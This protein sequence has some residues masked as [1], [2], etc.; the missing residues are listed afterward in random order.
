MTV[1]IPKFVDGQLLRADEL[2]ALYRA[3]VEVA[4]A[5]GLRLSAAVDWASGDPVLPRELN[6]L[7]GD[8]VRAYEHL[9]RTPPEWSFGRFASGMAITASQLNEIGNA[10]R[11]LLDG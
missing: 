10:V 1:H 6:R 7:L 2:N 5:R 9:G 8:T 11:S 3:L 4:A